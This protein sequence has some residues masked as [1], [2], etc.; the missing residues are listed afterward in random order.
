MPVE[1]PRTVPLPSPPPPE[2]SNVVAANSLSSLTSAAVTHPR[3]LR[4]MS[5]VA[6]DPPALTVPE[7][8]TGSI[9]SGGLSD[10]EVVPANKR[11]DSNR[12]MDEG[13]FDGMG[14]ASTGET[15]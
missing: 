4:W 1:L 8:G 7:N 9:G 2:S 12:S 3:W 13:F 6:G 10:A 11:R 5:M 14:S 15:Q